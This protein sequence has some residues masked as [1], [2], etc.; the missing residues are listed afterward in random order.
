MIYNYST[1]KDFTFFICIE[2][3]GM[4]VENSINLIKSM[5]KFTSG[6]SDCS[7]YAI[8]PRGI[9][10]KKES[11]YEL[12][13]LNVK[14]L[15]K[16]L[17]FTD[18]P[19]ANK[20]YSGKYLEAIIDTEYLVFI[21]SDSIFLNEPRELFLLEKFDV[22]L[23]PV[24]LKGIGCSGIHDDSYTLWKSVFS[25]FNLKVSNKKI[26]T[27]LGNEEIFSYY[28]SGFVAVKKRNRFF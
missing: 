28:N 4:L 11:I 6:F 20:L 5:R 7:I 10:L 2:P 25:K 19:Y 3:N 16:K 14:Y 27:K 26:T 18:S 8:S 24:W 22:A 9:D 15:C 17:N 21:D 1:Y 23:T 13:S 12:N